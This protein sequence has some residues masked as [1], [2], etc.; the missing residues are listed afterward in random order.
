M[1]TN[2]GGAFSAASLGPRGR[3][4]EGKGEHEVA[5]IAGEAGE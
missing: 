5:K 4:R 2:D 3:N 1:L